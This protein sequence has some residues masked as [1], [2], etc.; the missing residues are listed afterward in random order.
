MY[1]AILSLYHTAECR[2]SYR[3]FGW[4]KD[5]GLWLNQN[6]PLKRKVLT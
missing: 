6:G 3:F 1:N 5:S 4:I 2:G